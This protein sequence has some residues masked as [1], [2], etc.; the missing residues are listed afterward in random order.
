MLACPS[1]H[2]SVAIGFAVLVVVL[3]TLI[4]LDS[5]RLV[6]GADRLARGILRIKMRP[7][8]V[9]ALIGA[10]ILGGV[11]LNRSNYDWIKTEPVSKFFTNKAPSPGPGAL[12]RGLRNDA[13]I[14]RVA[15]LTP[16]PI[17][18]IVADALRA[19][20]AGL[21]PGQTTDTA[22]LQSLAQSGYLYDLGPATAA[23]DMSY[24]GITA[25]HGSA[26]WATIERGG[27][28]M[29][30]DVLAVNGFESHFLLTGEPKNALNLKF[31]YGPNFTTF[32]GDS[33]PDAAGFAD[34]R[35]Q[36]KRL[37]SLKLRDLNRSFIAFHMMS[38]HNAA[39][40]GE[41]NVLVGLK[42][43]ILSTRNNSARYA[44]V[45]RQR[46]RQLD[47]RLQAIFGILKQRGLLK[48]ALIIL[49]ADHGE[50]FNQKC[51]RLGHG[52]GIDPDTARIPLL[53]YDQR[54]NAWKR[55]ANASQI[56]IAPTLLAAIGARAPLTWRGKPLQQPFVRGGAPIDTIDRSAVMIQTGDGGAMVR[57]KLAN[58][59]TDVIRFGTAPA[60]D[61][62]TLI[63]QAMA[64]RNGTARR[65]GAARCFGR[66]K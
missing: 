30:A 32:Q 24:C 23:C 50:R 31:I 40:L 17:I 66:A 38:T 14:E 39:W 44:E 48:D 37:A 56:D 5:V 62:R 2:P 9:A 35:D 4:W 12:L 51:G 25:I 54:S 57:C 65:P 6:A 42:R 46:V 63:G 3:G 58:G 59:G 36:I 49:T 34:D 13:P 26:D 1:F 43:L 11:A 64:S 45:Y 18:L 19:D 10:A 53:I 29:L 60:A 47:N 7:V 8:T 27:P 15:I 52:F 21:M 61:D 28:T 33:A 55:S 22:F 41:N 16:R 20:G